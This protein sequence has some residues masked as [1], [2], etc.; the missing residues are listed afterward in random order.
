MGT[1]EGRSFET[2]TCL[3]D[4]HDEAGVWREAE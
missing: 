2:K 4:D 1:L 3:D